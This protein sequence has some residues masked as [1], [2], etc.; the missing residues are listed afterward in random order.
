MRADA[1]DGGSSGDDVDANVDAAHAWGAATLPVQ[2]PLGGAPPSHP[3]APGT[4]LL[5]Q[6][7]VPVG[8]GISGSSSTVPVRACASESCARA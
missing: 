1:E 7:H 3:V 5:S 4:T 6:L 2:A 8:I